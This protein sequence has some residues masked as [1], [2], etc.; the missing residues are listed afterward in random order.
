VSDIRRRPPSKARARKAMKQFRASLKGNKTG[1][2]RGFRGGKPPFNALYVV[3]SDSI[4]KLGVTS[5]LA[6]RLGQHRKQGLWKVVYILHSSE[7]QSLIEIEMIWK[8]FVR[9]QTGMKILREELPDGY[10]EAMP[11]NST[12]KTFI[13]HL[14]QTAPKPLADPDNS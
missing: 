14:L 6:A 1:Y 8:R 12:S 11:L 5:N 10:T 13:D 4:V 9:V 3:R 7:S 2:S